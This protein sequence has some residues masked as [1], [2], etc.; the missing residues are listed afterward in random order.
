M[1]VTAKLTLPFGVLPMGLGMLLMPMEPRELC[2]GELLETSPCRWI[3]TA[4]EK[5]ISVCGV[6][7]TGRGTCNTGEELR[8]SYPGDGPAIFLCL[9][10]TPFVMP[11]S[12]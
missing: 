8:D 9:C 11:A 4:M 10:L 3:T 2:I 1:T 5:P 6:H 7:P 12:A